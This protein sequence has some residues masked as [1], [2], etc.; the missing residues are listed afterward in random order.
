MPLPVLCLLLLTPFL[1]SDDPAPTKTVD[2][3][4]QEGLEKHHQLRRWPGATLGYV[5]PDGRTGGVA[6]GVSHKGSQ[7]PMKPTDRMFSGS[8]GKTY[9]AA[10]LL[11]LL[12]EG[13][14]DLD[15][16][17]AQWL[18]KEP[19]FARLPNADQI[20]LRMLLQHTSGVPEHVYHPAFKQAIA[21]AP[22]KVWKPA[23][24]V[25]FILDRKPLFEA[26][27]GW[28]YADTNYILLGMV[29]EKITGRTYYQELTDRILKKYK[30]EATSPV[31]RPDLP[32]L[33]SGYT[34]PDR[35]FPV[36][37]EV[38]TNGRYV[39]NPQLEWTG[40][41]LI[42]TATDLARWAKLL[43][44]GDVLK[45]TTRQQMLQMIPARPLGP[46]D[47]YGLGVQR[48]QSRHGPVL[49]HSGYF[50]GYISTLAYYPD[51]KIAVAVQINS[52]E[53]GSL[54]MMRAILDDAV[55]V[56]STAKP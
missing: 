10:V 30:L 43:Y 19:W 44:T 55:E 6:V 36:P 13:K 23:E 8:I 27:K 1:W 21:A 53:R 7:T 20:T 47:E 54:T 29:I 15:A 11:Q 42:S 12:E 5:L 18:G 37:A 22:Q 35:V 52:D 39:L 14:A 32:G 41:G 38:A 3:R 49:G 50:P 56:L 51:K 16:K 34:V 40:G 25:A 26:G 31:D 33:V 46:K 4:L 2:Q 48:W 24:L 28:S 17:L 9:V 45:E